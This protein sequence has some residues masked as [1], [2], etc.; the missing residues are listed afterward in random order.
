MKK[1]SLRT[2]AFMQ[3]AG[4]ATYILLFAATVQFLGHHFESVQVSP[5]FSMALV[6]MA[7]VFSATVCSAVFLGYPTYLFFEGKKKESVRLILESIVWLA[8]FL[9]VFLIL[10]PFTAS[11]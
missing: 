2:I 7:F 10:L 9:I 8:V 5:V 11:R 6:L 3:A 4:V 1:L